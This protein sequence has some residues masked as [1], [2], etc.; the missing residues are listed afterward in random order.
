MPEHTPAH[1]APAP[2]APPTTAEARARLRSALSWRSGAGTA[3]TTVLLAALGFLAAVQLAAPDDALGRATRA[4]LVEIL[5][6][7]NDQAGR[8]EEEIV[9]LEATRDELA[10]GAGDSVAALAEAEQRLDT[11]GILAGS[12]PASGPGV[13]LTISDPDGTVD[14]AAMLST[15]QE[16][17]GARAEAL[18]VTDAS[19]R[20]VRVVASTAFADVPAGGVAVGGVTLQPPYTIA[21]IGDPA[22]LTP[23]LRI[24]GGVVSSIEGSGA[25]ISIRESSDLAVDALHEPSAP[26]YARPATAEDIETDEG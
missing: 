19:D 7:L 3:V 16:L 8:L 26:S 20:A 21:A 10:A 4:D 13:E 12:V 2:P 1:G 15:V 9:R 14:A 25:T 24:P 18:Q 11:L 22:T 23:A 5:D 17:R 6:G